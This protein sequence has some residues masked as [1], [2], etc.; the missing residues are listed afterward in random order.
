[1]IKKA[2][3]VNKPYS[4]EFEERIYDNASPWNSSNWTWIKFTDSDYNEWVGQFRGAPIQVAISENKNETLVLTSD[5]L[6]R[7][8]NKNGDLIEFEDQPQYHNLTTSPAGDFILADHYNIN[9]INNR[10]KETVN[11]SS[12]IEMD[13]IKFRKWKERK[14]EFTCD[15]FTNWDRHLVMELDADK[16]TIEI[17]DEQK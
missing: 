3:I 14:L 7:L 10:L 11:I 6:F 1:M 8:E 9:L 16:L 15:E 12:P 17:K 13:M 5:Y 4:G 2:E